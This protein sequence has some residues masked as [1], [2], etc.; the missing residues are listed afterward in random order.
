[1]FHYQAKGEERIMKRNNFV[2]RTL[3]AVLFVLA[4][5]VLVPATGGVEARAAA[6]KITANKKYK[7]SPS[8]KLKNTY[9]VTVKA[10]DSFVKF[11]APKAGTYD[12]TL[13]NLTVYKGGKKSNDAETVRIYFCM[14]S[15]IS[16]GLSIQ[17]I[18]TQGGK[19]FYLNFCNAKYY[20]K[21]PDKTITGSSN[22]PKRKV[23]MKL[24]KGQTVYIQAASFGL[25]YSK[26]TCKLSV[27][28]K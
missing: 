12:F 14:K 15:K 24:K 28:K 18:K 23:T 6:K 11:K 27:K 22:L 10:G 2:K 8:I 1:L 25:D 19:A 20:K 13:S 9:T 3:V 17:R 21:Y 26:F 16:K 7:K 5:A 4:V